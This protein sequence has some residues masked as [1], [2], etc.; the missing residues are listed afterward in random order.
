ML[1]TMLPIMCGWVVAFALAIGAS[2]AG[3]GDVGEAAVA[4]VTVAEVAPASP[5]SEVRACYWLCEWTL[6]PTW[7]ACYSECGL[8]DRV[9]F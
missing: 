4:E 9:C 5:E 8:C 3:D 7:D 2:T 1:R 6:Y